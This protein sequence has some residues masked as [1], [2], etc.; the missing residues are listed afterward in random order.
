VNH[1]VIAQILH[2][3]NGAATLQLR[4]VAHSRFSRSKA[5]SPWIDNGSSRSQ[6]RTTHRFRQSRLHG[7]GLL[8]AEQPQLF[9]TVLYAAVIQCFQRGG[10]LRRECQHHGTAAA[11]FHIQF[12]AKFLH[13]LGTLYIQL[14]HQCTGFRIVTRV[15]D[16]AIG[17][18]SAHSDIVFPFQNQDPQIIL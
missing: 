12:P 1:I 2:T 17:L 10:L 15:Y 14:C 6:Q 18:G 5:Q 9:H 3:G 8:A 13:L 4:A 16:R 11:V 7:P